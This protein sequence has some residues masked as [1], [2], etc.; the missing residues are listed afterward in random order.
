LDPTEA[1]HIVHAAEI[2]LGNVDEA[3]IV[4]DSDVEPHYRFEPAEKDWPIKMLNLLSRSKF[5][6]K[7][8]LLNDTIFFPARWFANAC[9]A[10]K[11]RLH[12]KRFRSKTEGKTVE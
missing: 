3:R 10:V 2:G 8:V 4:L 12:G 5:M 7:H 1:R 11:A 9:R 6:T